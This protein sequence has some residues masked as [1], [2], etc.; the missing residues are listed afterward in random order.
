MTQLPPGVGW[1]QGEGVEVRFSL[2]A[3]AVMP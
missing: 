1:N 2:M 3:L